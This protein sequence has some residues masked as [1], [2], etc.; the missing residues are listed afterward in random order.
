M[1]AMQT[2]QPFSGGGFN[3][4]LP[5]MRIN[6]YSRVDETGA[7][8][9]EQLSNLGQ[10]ARTAPQHNVDPMGGVTQYN[11]ETGA[12]E[13]AGN[14]FSSFGL[15]GAGAGGGGDGG[16]GLMDAADTARRTESKERNAN[17]TTAAMRGLDAAMSARGIFGSRIHAG[18]LGDVFTRGMGEEAGT[19]RALT[20]ERGRR[21]QQVEDRDFGAA[22]DLR[23]AQFNAQNAR[24]MQQRNPTAAILAILANYGMQY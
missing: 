18:E 14:L 22:H 9:N 24:Q 19:D 21:S 8:E 4:S 3:R 15:F 7:L 6:P 17:R 2:L 16:G 10:A 12:W 20:V 5:G 13:P 1:A 11:Y 23:M